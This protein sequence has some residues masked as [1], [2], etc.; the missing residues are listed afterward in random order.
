[1]VFTC[2]TTD[3]S[4]PVK[5]LTSQVIQCYE[6][7]AGGEVSEEP[8]FC[9]G[10]CTYRMVLES[11]IVISPKPATL[12]PVF[13]LNQQ[14][15][16]FFLHRSGP[17]TCNRRVGSGAGRSQTEPRLYSLHLA[18][19]ERQKERRGVRERRGAAM[20]SFQ[21]RSRDRLRVDGYRNEA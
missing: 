5:S 6:G 20:P 12:A 16:A 9:S 11:I 21:D 8:L 1:M 18:T 19:S 14:P 15:S 7:A 2:R 13:H 10:F 17:L 4:S 3:R